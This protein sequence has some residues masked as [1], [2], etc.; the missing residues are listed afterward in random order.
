MGLSAGDGVITLRSAD[1]IEAAQWSLRSLDVG[2]EYAAA[3]AIEGEAPF[4]YRYGYSTRGS[5]IQDEG[6]K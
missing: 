6:T 2:P 3:V 4:I 5:S 1:S